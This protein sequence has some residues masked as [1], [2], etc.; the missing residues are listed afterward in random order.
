MFPAVTGS[1]TI[2]KVI[3]GTAQQL[4]VF[5]KERC[6]EGDFQVD[7]TTGKSVVC[8]H[9]LHVGRGLHGCIAKHSFQMFRNLQAE[10]EQ[11][12]TNRIDTFGGN[13]VVALLQNRQ[14]LIGKFHDFV[15]VAR[16]SCAVYFHSVDVEY[17]IVI[18]GEFQIDR[19]TGQITVNIYHTAHPDITGSPLGFCRRLIFLGTKGTTV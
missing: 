11:A 8:L 9:G 14:S 19:Y 13:D 16:G 15:L 17:G 5:H 18:V 3:H 10:V 7:I 12:V 6:R 1:N 4:Q 2:S